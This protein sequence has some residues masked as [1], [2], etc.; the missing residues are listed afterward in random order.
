ML[1]LGHIE[2]CARKG[3]RCAYTSGH[4]RTNTIYSNLQILSKQRF[5]VGTRQWLGD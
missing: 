4:F 5:S 2:H 3:G 1:D